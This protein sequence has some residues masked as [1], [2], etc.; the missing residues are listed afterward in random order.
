MALKTIGAAADNHAANVLPIIR[1]IGKAGATTLREI[2]EALNARGVQT[3]RGGQW[4]AMTVSDV[5]ARA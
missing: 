2:A 3:A 4:H 1:E 5:L